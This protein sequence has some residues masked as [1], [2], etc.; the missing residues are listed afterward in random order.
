MPG[1]LSRRA[2]LTGSRT[3]VQPPS[4]AAADQPMIAEVGAACISMRGVSCRLC[5]DPCEPDAI[6]FRLLTGG[7]ALPE[8]AAETCTGCGHCLGACPSGALVLV[9]SPHGVA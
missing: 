2:L 9:P 8:I 5:L 6:R 3:K 1:I 7:R 4:Q